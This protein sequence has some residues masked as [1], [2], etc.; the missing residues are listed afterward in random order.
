MATAAKQETSRFVVDQPGGFVVGKPRHGSAALDA[1]LGAFRRS[2]EEAE[3]GFVFVDRSGFELAIGAAW[4]A[5]RTPPFAISGAIAK[6]LIE[7]AEIRL[8][9]VERK[10][11]A[12]ALVRRYLGEADLYDVAVDVGRDGWSYVSSL[13]DELDL[14]ALRT[15]ELLWS[16]EATA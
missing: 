6:V 16:A 4:F 12:K 9:W 14:D 7:P 15:G 2:P 1:F 13:D 8:L 5:E 10:N 11:G 3:R